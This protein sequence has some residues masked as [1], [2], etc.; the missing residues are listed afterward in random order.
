MASLEENLQTLETTKANL[1]TALESKGVDLTDVP[2]T[3]Y[4]EKMN[5]IKDDTAL[6]I[7][8]GTLEE[9][10]NTKWGLSE[11]ADY[12]FYNF[13]NLKNVNFS[14]LTRIPNYTCNGCDN[15]ENIVLPNNLIYIGVSAF[16]YSGT[17][18]KN[19]SIE[20]IFEQPCNIQTTAFMNRNIKSINGFLSNLGTSAF[21][22]IK[23]TEKIDITLLEGV[24][25]SV[26]RSAAVQSFNI[27]K[28]SKIISL[29][30][31]SFQDCGSGRNN[32]ESNIFTFDFYN[33]TFTVIPA[34]CFRGDVSINSY[35]NINFNKKL[36]NIGGNVFSK[37]DHMTLY[38]RSETPPTLNSSS[39]SNATNLTICVPYNL[40]NAYKT[41]TNWTTVADSIRGFAEENAFRQGQDLPLYSAEGYALTWYSDIDLTQQVT[42]ADNPE[43]FYYCTISGE[44]VEVVNLNTYVDN[45]SLS[46]VDTNENFY[47]SGSI[48]VGT[49]LTI[50]VT[51]TDNYIPY[52]QTFNNETFTSPLSYTTVSGTDININAIYYDG[53]NVPVGETFADTHLAVI[54]KVI[55]DGQANQYWQV[56]DTKPLEV[57]GETYHVRLSDTQIGRYAY[58]DGTRTTN[59]VLEFVELW[60][61]SYGM[62]STKT[63]AGGWAECELG[64][65]INTEVLETLPTEL[66][67]LLE[68]VVVASANTGS[69]TYE[70]TTS[71]NKLFIPCA[72]EVNITGGYAYEGEGTTWD[73]YIGAGNSSR[74]KMK[75]NATSGITWWLRSPFPNSFASFSHVVGNG[76]GGNASA[77]FSGG[78]SPCWAW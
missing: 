39:F 27:K 64:I 52:I 25:N 54:K 48:P 63:N 26:F 67:A 38:F 31:Y 17:S 36:V 22:G 42:T 37:T 40:V 18:P 68:E 77:S 19:N 58:A 35:F 30:N 43:N 65:T 76:N 56:G 15:L 13:E 60:N 78:V 3:Q 70:I 4:P 71:N 23:N 55:Q 41:A 74:I 49:Q 1:K 16:A 73:Y 61:T 2:F 7:L 20:L 46:I 29:G 62:N 69:S 44:A 34:G 72:Y 50:T 11:I 8:D 59:A 47:G 21:Q 32:P 28:E 75:P 57:E 51:P 66:K 9:F 53:V 5:D 33:S 10:D 12:R 24:G 6:K 14:G 45:C